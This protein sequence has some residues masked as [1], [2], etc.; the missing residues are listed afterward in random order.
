[1]VLAHC[2]LVV[3]SMAPVVLLLT[4]TERVIAMF[5]FGSY[6]VFAFVEMLRTSLSIFAVNHAWRAGYEQ[7]SNDAARATF[8][9]AIE[10]FTGVNDALFFLFF[11]AFTLG[12]FC[13]GLA[14]LHAHGFD[15]QIAFLFLLWALLN[16]PGLIAFATGKDSIG[17]PFAWVGPYFQ[18][19][20]R[21]LIGAWL[22]NVSNRLSV[23]THQSPTHG[24]VD[25]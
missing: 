13:Y 5:G 21:F 19:A 8:R 10:A 6:I 16:F 3:I 1:M 22:W 9:S 12:L 4:G 7:A 23:D 18:P 11:A 25:T 17:A 24:T 14:P 20:A 2:V 15:R